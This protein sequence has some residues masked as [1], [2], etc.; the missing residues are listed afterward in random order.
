ML[1]GEVRVSGRALLSAFAAL[2]EF[3]VWMAYRLGMAISRAC[4]SSSLREEM[5]RTDSY[6]QASVFALLDCSVP[7]K[8]HLI[9]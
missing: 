7:M 2:I 6:I 4:C 3:R 9:S 5:P 1:S 8:C